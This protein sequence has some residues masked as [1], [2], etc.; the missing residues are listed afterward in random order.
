M[1]R[2]ASVSPE[3]TPRKALRSDDRLSDDWQSLVSSCGK[4]EDPEKLREEL[5]DLKRR[6]LEEDPYLVA[7]TAVRILR[8]G[9]DAETGIRF[10][11][12]PGR[13]LVGWPTLRVFLLDLLA[14]CDPD[15]AVEIARE[16]LA[17]TASAE[18]YAV[19]LKPLTMKGPWRAPDHEL[20]AHF[21]KLL[22]TP[23]WQ[24]SA[25]LAEGLDLARNIGTSAA[26]AAL[27]AWV[28][29]RPAALEAGK[30][31]LHETAAKD[32]G[33]LIGL[34][35]GDPE[36]FS[37]QPDLRAGLMARA[38]PSD[39]EQTAT[40]NDYL[41]NSEIPAVEKR[42]FLKLYPLRSA[43]TGYRLYG[44]PPVPYDRA[45]VVADDRQA[46]AEV[47]SWQADPA[48]AELLPEMHALEERLQVWT[49]QAGE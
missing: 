40:I 13:T 32:P 9:G 16:V 4:S 49:R 41:R 1:A 19:A 3:A 20:E 14:I 37:A 42:Q 21:A 39:S 33:L 11:V 22:D 38:T 34:I 23:G 8:A 17:S 18:E 5:A 30:M 10:E 48:L 2:A 25:G 26:A 47:Q 35:A 43:S 27:A 15:L 36:V 44:N 45:G 31:A 29:S 7:Q 46:L 24:T 12:G 28:E 6:W